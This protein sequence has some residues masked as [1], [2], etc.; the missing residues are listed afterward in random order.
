LSFKKTYASTPGR[1]E[2][3]ERKDAITGVRV[4]L[5]DDSAVLQG[6]E[7]SVLEVY[8]P[9]C[10]STEEAR[11]FAQG[12]LSALS[13]WQYQPYEAEDAFVDPAAQIGDGIN[14]RG[15]YSTIYK[16]TSYLGVQTNVSV[17]A[18]AEEEVNHE[19]PWI[20]GA[21]RKETR[22]YEDLRDNIES[23]L[24]VQAGL[25]SAKVSKVSPDGQT[26]FAWAMNDTSHVWSANGT[27]VFRL[28]ATGAH[29][30]GE[31]TATSGDIGGCSIVNGV[32]QVQAAS[33]KQLQIGTNFSVDT[34]GNMIAN[35]A[36]ITGTLNVGGSLISATDMYTGAAQ[37][38]AKYGGWDSAFTSTSVG[39][40]CA[41]GAALGYD[42][43]VATTYN[44]GTYP[45]YFTCGQINHKNAYMTFNGHILQIL[46]AAIGTRTIYYLGY[47]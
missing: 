1:F 47:T 12:I 21:D 6:T 36:T 16:R 18:P 13:G 39:G 32:L 42:Y 31:I 25:I 41:S 46:Q 45:S 30:K 23:E 14:M 34:A 11:T 27:E 9:L 8:I 40:Y 24:T 37:S 22:K 35:N 15:V 2:W 29:V 33:I 17:S 26:S 4:F 20:S 3:S 10:T 7:D 28:D 38:A 5:T 19:Y 44:T 43:G